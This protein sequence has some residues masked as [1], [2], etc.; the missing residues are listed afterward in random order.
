MN[1]TTLSHT[2]LALAAAL[3]T[4]LTA[5][6]ARAGVTPEE[7]AQLKTT[8]SPMGAERAGNKE[9]TIPAWSGAPT[10]KAAITPEG[11]RQD[12]FADEKPLFSVDAKTMAPHAD[13]LT[14]GTK[15]MMQKYPDFRIDVYKTHRTAIAPQ[16]VYD[17]TAKNATAASL[18]DG[19][20]GPQP[21]GAYGGVP[22]PIPKN[23]AEAVWNH[24]LAWRGHAWYWEF[25]GYQLSADG[26]WVL[27]GDS[28]NDQTMPYYA[29]AESADKFGGEYWMVRSLT[30]GPAIRAGEAITGRLQL[31]ESK[32][33]SWVYLTGQRRVRKLPNACCDTPTPFSAGITSFDEVEVFATR[34][35]RFDWKLVGKK[36]MLIPY[37]SNRT[38][39]PANDADVLGSR[40]LNPDHVRWELHRVWVVE[41]ALK[42]GQRH[43]SPKSRYYL[44]EDSWQAVLAERYDANGQVAR[45]PFGLPTVMSDIP[46]T[47]IVTWGVYD[48]T[49]GVSYVNG[50]LNE[51]RA[52]YKPMPAYK[53]AVFT[54]DAMAGDGV[55]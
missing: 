53:D 3:A 11:R 35:D 44:D 13:R 43:T 12:P 18:V 6:L 31:D 39:V 50:L 41:A 7:A 17:A 51:R 49:S 48:L 30:R 1:H 22:F 8:L 5:G 4:L 38:H 27:A 19:E 26:K 23:G 52:P 29:K 47:A 16:A 9:G 55:R 34:L 14:A 20:A 2:A 45:V 32:T 42:P 33:T 15:A 54:P 25:H 21:Q 40:F 24:K 37:N 46:A 36:E 28:A 10:V